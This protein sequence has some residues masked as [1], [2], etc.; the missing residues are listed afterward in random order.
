MKYPIPT[1]KSPIDPILYDWIDTIPKDFRQNPG[2]MDFLLRIC[3]R[4]YEGNGFGRESGINPFYKINELLQASKLE[5]WHLQ[6]IK[7]YY[8]FDIIRYL[9]EGNIAENYVG[10]P[11]FNARQ[12]R[13]ALGVRKNVT[14]KVTLAD[15]L[16][17]IV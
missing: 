10:Y 11:C 5:Y 9:T 14:T 15:I 12:L 8:H 2:L 17:N 7:E 3:H 16:S 1:L 13:S 6:R 4:I